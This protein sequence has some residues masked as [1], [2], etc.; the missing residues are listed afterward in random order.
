MNQRKINQL[1]YI[2]DTSYSTKYI[3]PIIIHRN[4]DK[5]E[6]PHR[7]LTQEFIKEYGLYRLIKRFVEQYS[8]IT[9]VFIVR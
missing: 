4:D 7:M 2:L 9:Y 5:R 3:Q 6:A 1:R 8:D